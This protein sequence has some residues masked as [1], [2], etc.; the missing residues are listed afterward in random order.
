MVFW[1]SIILNNTKCWKVKSIYRTIFLAVDSII[2]LSRQFS[3][4]N[5][6]KIQFVCTIAL[7]TSLCF[8]N[9]HKFGNIDLIIKQILPYF[10]IAVFSNVYHLAIIYISQPKHH[11]TIIQLS[12]KSS[13]RIFRH[14]FQ[15]DFQRL[16][17]VKL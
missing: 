2:A 12:R 6:N 11:I 10:S 7:K 13:F 8:H 14:E 3:P 5:P 17:R 9:F 4:S 1:I 15:I 16:C